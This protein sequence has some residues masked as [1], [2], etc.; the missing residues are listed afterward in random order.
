MEILDDTVYNILLSHRPEHFNDYVESGYDLVLTGHAHGGQ[1]RL[2]VLGG[3]I[4]PHQGILPA[5]DAGAYTSGSTTMIV[6]RGLGN[7]LFPFRM[8]N[9]PELVVIDLTVKVDVVTFCTVT[10][11]VPSIVTLVPVIVSIVKVGW[12]VTPS[13][14]TLWP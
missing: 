12:S 5:Y 8:F 11:V 3:V 2:P 7:S 1:L 14:V 4:A 6:S 13:T 9:N 10:F